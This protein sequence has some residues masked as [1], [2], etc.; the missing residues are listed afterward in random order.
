VT[1]DTSTEVA[2]PAGGDS[3]GSITSH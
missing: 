3:P 2:E 1:A